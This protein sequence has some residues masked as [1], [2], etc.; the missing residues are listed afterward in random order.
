MLNH[1]KVI[2]NYMTR[3]CANNEREIVSRNTMRLAR[4][5]FLL[6]FFLSLFFFVDIKIE[7]APSIA[8]LC[9]ALL[10][11]RLGG[12]GNRTRFGKRSTTLETSYLTGKSTYQRETNGDLLVAW[13]LV[14]TRV[15]V[16]YDCDTCY[17]RYIVAQKR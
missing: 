4:F 17:T 7:V 15:R 6:S 5:A 9:S 12:E 10:V 13:T 8:N 14:M 2:L 11:T 1:I 3:S 16:Q